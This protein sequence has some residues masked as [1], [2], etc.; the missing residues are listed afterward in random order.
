MKPNGQTQLKTSRFSSENHLKIPA[1]QAED[2]TVFIIIL[3]FSDYDQTYRYTEI[4]ITQF[5][6]F[7][8]KFIKNTNLSQMNNF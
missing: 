3:K 2:R 1:H 7:I 8:E 5:R 4:S 6:V